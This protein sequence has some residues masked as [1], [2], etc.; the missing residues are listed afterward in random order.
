M[1]AVPIYPCLL[2]V[3]LIFYSLFFWGKQFLKFFFYML[4]KALIKNQILYYENKYWN[5]LNFPIEKKITI[6]WLNNDNDKSLDKPNTK[7]E[8]I[9]ILRYGHK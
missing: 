6:E 3:K 8:I 4:Y 9:N 1:W 7:A 5:F 2:T